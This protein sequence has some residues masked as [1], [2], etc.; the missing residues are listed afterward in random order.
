MENK[1]KAPQTLKKVCLDTPP[2]FSRGIL[3]SATA[4]CTSEVL[5]GVPERI[6]SGVSRPTTCIGLR[7][8]AQTFF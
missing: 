8:Q 3:G 2:G 6:G 7:Q 1:Y 5:H 4:A